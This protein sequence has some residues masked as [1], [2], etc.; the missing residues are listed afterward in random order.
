MHIQQLDPANPRDVRR[1]VEFPFRL[2]RDEPLW[3]PPFVSEVRATLESRG[4]DAS[5]LRLRNMLDALHGEG[6]SSSGATPNTVLP[7]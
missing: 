4:F 7:Y 2:Y 6:P 1:F 3:V 5:I